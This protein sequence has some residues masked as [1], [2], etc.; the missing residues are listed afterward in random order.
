MTHHA[1]DAVAGQTAV[2]AQRVAW[3]GGERLVHGE[4]LARMVGGELALTHHAMAVQAEVLDLSAVQLGTGLVVQGL[5]AL[6]LRVE[7]RIAA[8]QPHHRPA[9]FRPSAEAWQ[10]TQ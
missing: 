8:G 7:D 2:E 1:R 3:R 6:E 10:R 9:P 5:L 4:L